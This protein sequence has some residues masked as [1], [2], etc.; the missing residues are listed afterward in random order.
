MIFN[1][2]WLLVKS[3]TKGVL[4]NVLQVFLLVEIHV[5]A[6]NLGMG[7]HIFSRTHELHPISESVFE[8][9]RGCIASMSSIMPLHIYLKKRINF[10]PLSIHGY[11]RELIVLVFQRYHPSS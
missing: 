4:E 2:F 3:V 6:V 8:S 5:G 11:F 1:K 9:V 7:P 10:Q